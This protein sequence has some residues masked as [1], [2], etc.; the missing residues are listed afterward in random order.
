[1]HSVY[2]V[3]FDSRSMID[4]FGTIHDAVNA[5]RTVGLDMKPK[6]LQKQRERGNITADLVASLMQAS[7]NVKKPINPYD[8]LLHGTQPLE[9]N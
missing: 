3:K 2:S 4:H 6:T 8:Y 9:N 7:I 1:M 5:L